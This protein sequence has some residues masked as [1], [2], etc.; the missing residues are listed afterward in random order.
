VNTARRRY[1]FQANPSG[2][3]L[4][5]ETLDPLHDATVNPLGHRTIIAYDK[6]QFL[7]EAVTDAAG[8]TMQATY[9][10]RVLQP[11][12]VT[13][14]NDNKSRFAFSPLGLLQ[15]SMVS[16][17]SPT[18]GDHERSS[19]RMEYGFLAFENSPPDARQPVF[20]RTI[21]QI[22]HDTELDVPLPEREEAITT[23]EYSDGFGRL[24]QTRTQGEDVRFG[25]EHFG[26]GESVLP[27]KQGAGADLVGRRNTD[28]LRPNV[29]VSGWQIYDNKGQVVEK[30]EP[31]FSEGWDYGQPE[32]SET[33][34]KVSTFYDPRG[35]AIRTLNPDG[36]EQRVIFG[37]PGTIAA[38]DLT[39][40]EMFEP[41]PWEAFT[42]D[43]N[44]NAG[45]THPVASANYQHH[46]NTPAS[47][48]I[49][50]LGRT[51]EMVE[52]NRNPPA[53]PGDPLPP[54]QELI[55]Q[56][57]YDIRGNVLTI[58]DALGR[59]AFHSHVYD[60]A[61]HQLRLESLDAGLRKKV[62]D[63]A[64]GVVEQR[65]SKRALILHAYDNLNRP[66]RLWARDGEGQKL[67]MRERLEY[68][69]AGV[70]DQTAADRKANRAANRL[71]KLFQGF[72]EA[73]LLSFEAYDFKG[74]VLEKARR[75]ISDGTILA[76]FNGPPPVN[77]IEA[78]R[79]DWTNPDPGRLDAT[80]FA[81]NVSYDARNRVKLG[82]YPVDVENKRRKLRPV[83]DRAGAL[84]QVALERVAPDGGTIS[85]SFVE[86]IAYNAKGQRVFIAY[87][88]GI[89]TRYAY[90]PQTLR[91][92]HLRTER[93]SKPSELT[94]RPGGEVHQELAYE[95]DLIG[96]I[97]AIHDRTPGCGL[98]VTPD[99][100]DRAFTYDAL[101]RLRSA[102]GRECDTAPPIPPNSPWDDVPRC[103]DITRT[104]KY[105]ERYE[106][107]AVG[108]ILQL[109]HTLFRSDG[110]TQ[111]SNRNFT[112][113]ANTNRLLRVTFENQPFDYSYD[114]NGNM[115]GE[116]SSRHFE[117][118]HADRMKVY[119]TQTDGSEPTVHAHYLYDAGGQRV[120]KVVR[121]QVGQVE[122]TIYI[123]G[124]FELQR[125]VRGGVIEE[126]NTLHVVDNQSRIALVR[127][128]QPFTGD[129]TPAVKYH[130]GD[131]LGS[132]NLVID[133]SGNLIN[134]E[135]YM[136]YGET[137][138]GSF[139]RKRYRFTGKERDEE[140]GLSFH[141]ARYYAAWIL[142]WT[143]CDP[144][145]FE[146]G[147]N[148]FQYVGSNPVSLIDSQG[149]D[150]EPPPN[151][152]SGHWTTG[153]SGHTDTLTGQQ[154]T[155][156]SKFVVDPEEFE[157][158]VSRPGV[159]DRV[160]GNAKAE[161]DDYKAVGKGVVNGVSDWVAGPVVGLLL[162][163]FKVDDRNFLG[164][165]I[166]E[167]VG[168][169]LA[170]GA[171]EVAEAAETLR[172]ARAA[173]TAEASADG[174]RAAAVVESR[175][176]STAPRGPITSTSPKSP[177]GS[178][179][180]RSPISSTSPRSPTTSTAPKNEYVAA[181]QLIRSAERT[182][183]GIKMGKI[184][185]DKQAIERL[186]RGG[187]IHTPDK[188]VA[189]ALQK[190]AV[191]G[192]AIHDEARHPGYYNHFHD[193]KRSGGHAFYGG[194]RG[195]Q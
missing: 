19:V 78:F 193:A 92:Q 167:I 36:S 145:G 182:K 120:K 18:E 54:I 52:R 41:T 131:H 49:D 13:D 168:A 55:T 108:N 97:L 143:S 195:A 129:S 179:S 150:D 28:E 178:I 85:D 158:P 32:D 65:D 87:G 122:V 172:L 107:D 190:D 67:T 160:N 186:R 59:A 153:E 35:H 106:Y 166:G 185:T 119:R 37:V 11:S 100:L 22:H 4:V 8:L 159:Y 64:A 121:K 139:A 23:L 86:R 75:V 38:R 176:V 33:G 9:D 181:K 105:E 96:N 138:F 192:K 72:D 125:T 165:L 163:R 175:I 80:T 5:L 16:G 111:G 10:H 46:W 79:V 109:N 98:P 50:S 184:L 162:P 152:T 194:P 24:L 130:L 127:V 174:A 84:E 191:P 77:K 114:A 146:A 173:R 15:S 44:D 61:N 74:N 29:V 118:D 171:G 62:L 183:A 26:G 82:I 20:V 133:A 188:A 25:D 113:V 126:N 94:Y 123:D 81:S 60:Y 43:A 161:I 95:Y 73:G 69:D 6:F 170:G 21:R 110:S 88:N 51:I 56:A 31:F 128:G 2:R 149:T 164:L 17:K 112:L 70:P 91:L 151:S 115:I 124:A 34:Q 189:R 156:E 76:V 63:A 169:G 89:L 90:N 93:Y 53:D 1:D 132:S 14:S 147:V 7:P 144:I 99:E 140:S 134:R 71:G 136:P 103:T 12:E 137:S 40:P 68:G 141:E 117:W 57:T 27:A 142:R 83:Y 157:P 104:R 39:H 45:R 30:Y 135:E 48:L 101:S 155:A 66:I 154:V 47:I 3:G 148:L 177:I 58:T 180:P 102:D 116:S 42:Y 187:D